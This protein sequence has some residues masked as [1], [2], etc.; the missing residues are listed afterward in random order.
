MDQIFDFM[1][2]DFAG[3]ALQILLKPS[4]S[5]T[6]IDFCRRMVRKPVVDAGRFERVWNRHVYSLVDAYEMNP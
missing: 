3:Y 6:Q 2:R 1:I 5:H 4:S